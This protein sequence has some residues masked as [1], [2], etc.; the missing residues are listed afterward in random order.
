MKKLTKDAR[1]FVEEIVGQMK[2]NK[3][4]DRPL[5]KIQSLL[6]RVSEGAWKENTAKVTTAIP[7]DPEEKEKI[8]TILSKRL[9]Q[10]ITLDCTVQPGILAGVKVEIGD[11]I[12]D[13]S[14]EEK[15]RLIKSA[16]LKGSH[17]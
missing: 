8:A 4:T 9:D 5:P 11:L 13:L 12:I 2:K 14:Y 10:P 1:H 17:I 15:L 7:L 3:H 16:L 6:R